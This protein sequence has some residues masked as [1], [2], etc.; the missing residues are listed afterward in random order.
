M[1]LVC[2][3][4]PLHSGNPG[5]TCARHVARSGNRGVGAPGRDAGA[6]RVCH[7]RRAVVSFIQPEAQVF[8]QGAANVMAKFC[9]FVFFFASRASGERWV[10]KHRDTFLVSLDDAFALAKRLNARNFG[11]GLAERA[12]PASE[13]KTAAPDRQM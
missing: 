2:L 3:G 8:D 1:D 12:F 4:Q 10:A 9:H 5:A 6:G 7:S 13:Q 11:A